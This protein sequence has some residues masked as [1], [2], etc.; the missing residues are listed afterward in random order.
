[1]V[2][3][4]L[5]GLRARWAIEAEESKMNSL[6]KVPGLVDCLTELELRQVAALSDV[7]HYAPGALVVKEGT[8]LEDLTIIT[9]G[10]AS[11]SRHDEVLMESVG[12]G[13]FWG[14]LCLVQVQNLD[15]L[16]YPF[17][18][19]FSFFF[20]CFGLFIAKIIIIN[21]YVWYQYISKVA[22]LI[23][24][25]VGA[26]TM[27]SNRASVHCQNIERSWAYSNCVQGGSKF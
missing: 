8:L 27:S 17:V 24:S 16:L 18:I 19:Y 10:F 25:H 3:S 6:K 26:S 13:A 4:I 12:P 21:M 2:G 15:N 20:I 14:D 11:F 1:M 23:D 7:V 9:A 22:L 5:H